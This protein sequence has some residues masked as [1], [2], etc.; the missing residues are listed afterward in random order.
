MFQPV[1]CLKV[2]QGSG[3]L[4]LGGST[5]IQIGRVTG[6][7]GGAVLL[8]LH[9]V[10]VLG[11]DPLGAARQQNAILNGIFNVKQQPGFGAVVAVIHENRALLEHLGVALPHQINDG[12]QQRMSGTKQFGW[13]HAL[14]IAAL[15]FKAHPLVSLQHRFPKADL[16]ISAAH[17]RRH[18]GDLVAPG[19]SWANLAAHRAEGF[20]KECLD[21]VGLQ[22]VRLH[23][24]HLFPDGRDFLNVHGVIGQCAL[25]QQFPELLLVQ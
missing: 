19:L 18:K 2:G 10:D 14:H 16:H 13:Y 3:A 15:F 1:L 9:K 12:F 4:C 5:V 11:D 23:P 21:K 20:Q 24:L 6:A 7:A 25:I 22:L 8:Q 17:R